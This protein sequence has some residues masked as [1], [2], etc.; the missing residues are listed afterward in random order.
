MKDLLKRGRKQAQVSD[1][2]WLRT[3]IVTFFTRGR[4]GL[5]TAGPKVLLFSE[6]A[7]APPASAVYAMMTNHIAALA[8]I[9]LYLKHRELVSYFSHDHQN[10]WQRK[11]SFVNS[12]IGLVA[13]ACLQMSVNFP[14]NK[15]PYIQVYSNMLLMVCTVVYVWIHTT[16]SAFV[17]D[18]NIARLKL[19]VVRS[20][21][22]AAVT[23]FCGSSEYL[24]I[25]GGA[26]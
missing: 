1:R 4:T 8:A 5:Q 14:K 25:T 21:L 9:W 23:S 16:L 13:V 6:I 7:T 22:A 24:L 2:Y 20:L 18:A 26:A 17:I 12:C 11:I 19:F 15:V 10:S 3:H